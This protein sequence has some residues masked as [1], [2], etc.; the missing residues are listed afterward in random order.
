MR[1]VLRMLHDRGIDN[2][3]LNTLAMCAIKNCDSNVL[4]KC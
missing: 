3:S 1:T 4:E 2:S